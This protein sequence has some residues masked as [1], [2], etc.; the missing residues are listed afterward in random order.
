[1]LL[2]IPMFFSEYSRKGYLFHYNSDICYT[3]GE[4]VVS[5]PQLF[6]TKRNNKTF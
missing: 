6:V 1:M 4:N 5:L 2:L 3:I